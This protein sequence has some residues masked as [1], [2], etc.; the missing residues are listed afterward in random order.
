MRDLLWQKCT[1]PLFKDF[2]KALE[3]TSSQSRPVNTLVHASLWVAETRPSLVCVLG[4]VA[5]QGSLFPQ[6]E[7]SSEESKQLGVLSVPVQTLSENS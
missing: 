6:G 2:Y 4:A 3:Q 5:W 1:F 7:N